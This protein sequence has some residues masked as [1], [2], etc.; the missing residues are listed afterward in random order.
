[1]LT[2]LVCLLTWVVLSGK[3][4]LFHLS[5]GVVSCGIVALASGDMLFSARNAPRRLPGQWLRFILYVPWLLYQ[6]F[7]ANMHVMRLVF[8]PRMMDLINPQMVKFKSRLN[9]EMARF[10]YANSITLTPGTITVYV[11]RYGDYTVHA[12][13]DASAQSLPGE[14][15]TMVAKI[16]GE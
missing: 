14:M 2:F 13:D 8:H 6:I 1:M 15:E 16:F 5:L 11:S 7:R 10:V 3:F 12:I 4:D 9:G